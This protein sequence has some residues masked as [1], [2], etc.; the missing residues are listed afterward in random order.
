MD[1]ITTFLSDSN[2][3]VQIAAIQAFVFMGRAAVAQDAGDLAKMANDASQ[4]ATV[5]RLAQ[6]VIDGKDERMYDP[7]GRTRQAQ[8]LK[9]N[10]SSVSSRSRFFIRAIVATANVIAVVAVVRSN[11]PNVPDLPLHGVIILAPL[12]VASRSRV[13]EAIWLLA[14]FVSI[15]LT[16]SVMLL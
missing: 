10:R 9:C 11:Q 5:R 16:A 6:D 7:V 12:L 1:R 8:Q 3:Q 13:I 14:T 2:E 4:T 15:G